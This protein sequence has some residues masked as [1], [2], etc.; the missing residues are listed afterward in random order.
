MPQ[1]VGTSLDDRLQSQVSCLENG[2]EGDRIGRQISLVMNRT[3]DD[4]QTELAEKLT[5]IVNVSIV[6]INRR[7]LVKPFCTSISTHSGE[8][9]IQCQLQYELKSRSTYP[10]NCLFYSEHKLQTKNYI[11]MKVFLLVNV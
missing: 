8:N 9:T 2:K 5:P 4:A 10:W 6:Y 7:L 1:S 3:G 11:Q